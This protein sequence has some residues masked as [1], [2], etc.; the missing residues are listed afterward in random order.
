LEDI[1]LD[2]QEQDD[3][4]TIDV[5]KQILALEQEVKD[6]KKD[7][8]E[9]WIAAKSNGVDVKNSKKAV[10]QLKKDYKMDKLEK[11]D[12]QDVI[13]LLKGDVDIHAALIDLV[14]K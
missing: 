2:N 3:K 9:H 5:I 11:Q 12:I 10:T 13:N 6:I 7:I 8:S 4:I 14:S 1:I